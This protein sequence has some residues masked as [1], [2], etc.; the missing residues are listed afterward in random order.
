MFQVLTEC[1]QRWEAK[2]APHLVKSLWHCPFICLENPLRPVLL[3]IFIYLLQRSM[4]G[5][6]ISLPLFF[7]FTQ[8]MWL[9]SAGHSV[10][11]PDESAWSLSY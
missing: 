2:F 5:L 10:A 3:F 6:R 1:Q 8:S 9:G 7:S 11:F 4:H